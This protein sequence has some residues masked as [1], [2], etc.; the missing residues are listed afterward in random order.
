GSERVLQVTTSMEAHHATIMSNDSFTTDLKATNRLIK[1]HFSAFDVRAVDMESCAFA[2]ACYVLGLP[3]IA[4]RAISDVVGSSNQT[5][6]FFDNLDEACK[7][8][9]DFILD[10]L[11]KL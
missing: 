7:C 3:F 11:K 5:V 2:Q 6:S 9:N 8:S 4:I 1:K 10:L